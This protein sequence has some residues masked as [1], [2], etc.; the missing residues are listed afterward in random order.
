VLR[1]ATAGSVDDGKSTLIGR[2]LFDSKSLMADQ[3]AGL[4]DLALLTDGLRAER[5]QGITIDVAYRHFAT[6]SRRFVLHDCP[7]HAQYTRNMATGASTA[8]LALILVDAR[9]GMTEQSRRHAAIAALLRVPQVTVCVNKMDLVDWSEEAFDAVCRE[10]LDFASELGLHDIAFIP[11]S[12]LEGDNVVEPS[13]N[14]PW[15][16]GVPLLA[17]LEAAPAT[18]DVA[19]AP[20]RLPVQMVIRASEAVTSAKREADEVRRYAGRLASGAL[21]AGDE[22]VVLPAGLRTRVTVVEGPS[23][24]RDVAFAPLSVT[25]GLEDEI[26]V[27]RGDLIAAAYEAPEPVRELSATVCWLGD[28]PA[29]PGARFL[30]KHTTRTVRAR[31]DAVE[32]RLDVT[33][34]E[35]GPAESLELNDIGTLRLRLGEPVMADRYARI[36]ST[37]A[38][39]LIDEATNETVGAGMIS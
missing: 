19:D 20:A 33:S 27:A 7:G 15:Y 26:D 28:A 8:D 10:F 37:G 22:V 39:V 17:H 11:V 31:V 25:V 35:R 5:E 14:M 13:S 29:R 1:V 9:R 34:L 4:E 23:G 38:F 6:P 3:E 18:P 32:S 16:G 30:L 36:R 24:P 12:A 2:L 21:R